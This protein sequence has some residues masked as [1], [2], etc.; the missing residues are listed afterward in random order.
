MLFRKHCFGREDSVS[1]A[2]NSVS[3]VWHTKKWAE[4]NSLSFPELGERQQKLIEF[5]GS[6]FETMLSEIG[7]KFQPTPP[8]LK[9]PSRMGG[10]VSRGKGSYKSCRG[11]LLK[12]YPPLSP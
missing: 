7:F 12:I 6:V 10:G 9:Y 8:P 4:S 11:G 3:L 1:S 5:L 2:A